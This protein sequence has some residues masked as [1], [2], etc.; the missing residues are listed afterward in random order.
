[1]YDCLF[2]YL[3][4]NLSLPRSLHGGSDEQA[5]LQLYA[6]ALATDARHVE[7][8]YNRGVSHQ[9]LGELEVTD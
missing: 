5:A 3:L 2:T 9:H 7:A 4:P 1:M 8:W 6:R